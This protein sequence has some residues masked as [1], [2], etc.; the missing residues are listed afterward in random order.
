METATATCDAE[1]ESL[2]RDVAGFF[3]YEDHE[4]KDEDMVINCFL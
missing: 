3:I 1:R 4:Q 2:P